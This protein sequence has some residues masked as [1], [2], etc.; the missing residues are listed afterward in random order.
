M[1]FHVI[2]EAD[3]FFLTD[4]YG[5]VPDKA[6]DSYGYGLFTRDTR[7]LSRFEC[8]FAP[9]EFTL[10][11]SDTTHNY[12]N[13]YRLMNKPATDGSVD[14]DSLFVTRSQIV[15]G[16]RLVENMTIRNYGDRQAI[17][18][19]E[20]R[21]DSDFDDMFEVRGY[22][23]H[24]K[25][26]AVQRVAHHNYL[27]F[28]YSA[29]DG[30]V[31]QTVVHL[32]VLGNTSANV[33]YRASQ[34]D[35]TLSVRT[36][37][38]IPA[39][40]EVA[41][42]VTVYPLTDG[43]I[44]PTLPVVDPVM[45]QAKISQRYDAWMNSVPRVRSTRSFD[46][47][48]EQGLR[49]VRMLLT[50]VGYGALPTA[51]VPWYAVP[52]GRDSLITSLQLLP[53][54]PEVARATLLTMSV[55]QGTQVRPDRDEQPGKIMHEMRVGEL[56]RIGAVPFGPYFGSIDST[57][58]FLILVVEYFSFTSDESLLEQI[59]PHVSRALAWLED[60]GDRDDD[61]FVEY[62]E[63]ANGGI[64]N[65][66]W[67]DSGDSVRHQNGDF[68]KAPIALCEVQGYSYKAL[69]GCAALYDHAGMKTE[70]DRCHKSADQLATHFIKEFWLENQSSI[71][72][73]LD[74]DK[75]P[76]AVV[77]SN[78]GQVLFSGILPQ[79]I[80]DQL[81][82][83]LMQDDMFTGYGIRTLSQEERVYNPL[84]YHNGS[85]WPHDNS[86]IFL[87]MQKYGHTV[88]MSRVISGL[89]KAASHFELYRL[90]ELFCGF[91][92][93]QASSPVPYLVSCSPQAW[94]A[95]T[96]VLALQ[97]LLG[98]TVD[99]Y[100]K[101]IILSPTLLADM[102]YM[103]IQG[104]RLGSGQLDLMISRT[105]Q[106]DVATTVVTN[107]TGWQVSIVESRL[108]GDDRKSV[109]TVNAG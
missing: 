103:E 56:T 61:G 28:T 12:Q 47:W 62:Y 90:P 36:I 51:G 18:P 53:V 108:G 76:V 87:G 84:S 91:S 68:A 31:I 10:L 101:M 106:G 89:L 66:G 63:E 14:R 2:K 13:A 1:N 4:K 85:V 39:G 25:K 75:R 82:D 59:L 44:I 60:Y 98:L 55:H 32:N 78:M 72:L 64:A 50:D 30:Q 54:A 22:A 7:V 20:Y 17:L 43:T 34:G 86:L 107:T 5:F 95:A 3:L 9:L 37:L 70:A 49:D 29:L 46:R 94:A 58:L 81:I 92:T 71:A 45:I 15:D 80:A 67:K 96:P 33:N 69:M 24:V 16:E 23:P 93:T 104:L 52:F 21:L 65:Q 79:P 11:D 8:S 27:S 97:A 77:S 100:N 73:A 57:L 35:S 41:L 99:G 109:E 74:G 102:P 88:A 40:E 105:N 83:R 26:S 38:E 19:V 48:Y 42:V 6:K